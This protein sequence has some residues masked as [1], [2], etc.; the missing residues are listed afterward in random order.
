[1]TQ[2][3]RFVCVGFSLAFLFFAACSGGQGLSSRQ[4]RSS[5][6]AK[7][8]P[9]NL[10]KKPWRP[11]QKN[12]VPHTM[13]RHVKS[14]VK[15]FNGPLRKNFARWVHRLGE[16]GPT[17]DA[18]LDREKAP[19]DLI[20]LAMIESGFNTRAVSHASAVG[21]WQFISSTG[22]MYGLK[23]D[24]FVDDRQNVIQATQAAARHLKDLHKIYKDWYLA[25]AAYNA[26]PGNVN[27]GIKR[28]KS[29]NFWRMHSK[30]K[31]L[32]RET[33][34]YVPKYLAARHIVKN[35]RK[36]GYNSKSFGAP[37]VYDVVRVPDATDINT[38]AYAAK[39]DPKT[40]LK[41]NPSLLLGI[42]PP[43][44]SF[45]V[46]VPEDS[47][48]HFK[49]RYQRVPQD[50][51]VSHLNY[52]A[53]YKETLAS[54]GKNYGVN[55]N[56]LARLNKIRN[57]KSTLKSGSVI[58]IPAKQKTLTAF[59]KLGRSGSKRSSS[60]SRWAT[61]KVKKGDTLSRIARKNKTSV[62]KIAKWNKIKTSSTLRIGQKL[63]LYKGKVRSSVKSGQFV[64]L[65]SS[66]PALTYSQSKRKRMSGVT[67][68]IL[69]DN[70][71][72]FGRKETKSKRSQKIGNLIASADKTNWGDTNDLNVR[73]LTDEFDANKD[74]DLIKDVIRKKAIKPAPNKP[75]VY[76]VRAG[77]TLSGIAVKNRVSVARL[78]EYN[79]LANSHIRVGQK[80]NLKK[81]PKVI[82]HKVKSGDTLWS[83][84]KKYRVSISKIKRWNKLKS[85]VVRPNQKIKI[86]V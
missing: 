39:S 13:N 46:Y 38:L 58:K 84:A 6:S 59:A 16:Y 55:A 5:Y 48:R 41:L 33:K 44:K 2:Y 37:L 82:Y 22:K 47:A 74:K 85:D 26:G 77:D 72:E 4:V 73:D 78:K 56:E 31:A 63:K 34:D 11:T 21:P 64:A 36:Y 42:T 32:P 51:R 54:I 1:M 12:V 75:A 35:Y 10:S 66:Q 18:I 27:R 43:G 53:G 71:P 80:L 68:I 7:S 79:K 49:Q 9:T 67:H 45:S 30:R 40:L 70:S 28:A 83:L 14:W 25:F 19:R 69:N 60:R 17:I 61:Y 62:T 57:I 3:K 65:A 15:R 29:R 86:V 52:R 23:S 50:K 76:V 81:V 24:F 20:Y 8:V